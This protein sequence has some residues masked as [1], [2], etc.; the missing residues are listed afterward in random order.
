MVE[1]CVEGGA[2]HVDISGEPQYLEKMQLTY[3]QVTTDVIRNLRKSPKKALENGVYVVGACGFDSI[4]ADM[5]QVKKRDRNLCR[6]LTAGV[7][8]GRN[9]G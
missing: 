3:H 7:C 6:M 1:A 8:K 4:P 5:G 2:P 9:G